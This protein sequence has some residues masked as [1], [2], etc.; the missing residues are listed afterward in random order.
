MTALCTRVMKFFS[1]DNGSLGLDFPGCM[2][3]VDIASYYI[4]FFI[5]VVIFIY[6]CNRVCMDSNIICMCAYMN[7]CIYECVFMYV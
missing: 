3:V 4:Y 1:W 5:E 6:I 2:S 7:A